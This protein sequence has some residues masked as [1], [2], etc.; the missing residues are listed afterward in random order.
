MGSPARIARRALGNVFLGV[1]IGL[2]GYYGLTNVVSFL[3]QAR[4][5]DALQ[6][7]GGVSAKVATDIA[8][9]PGPQFDFAGWEA[10]DEAYWK[11]LGEGDPFGRLVIDRMGLDV[12]VIK[13]VDVVDLKEGPG[14]AP[15]TN[16]PGLDGNC[17]ISGHRTTY[18]APFRQL[19]TI[20]SG[21]TIDLYSPFRRY[22]YTV[23]RMFIVNPGQVE[24]F[25]PTVTP[26]LTLTAC[27]PL[28]SARY[29]IVVQAEMSQVRRL[30]ATGR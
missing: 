2:L 27:H 4:L 19:D 30:A 26:T 18:M 24:V 7:F 5:R 9:T 22:R 14:W 13:G 28:Y 11:G 16:L 20:K 23:T 12:V 1:A 25:D 17:G 29:R 3:E 6:R 21:D 15:Y 8:V 10:E